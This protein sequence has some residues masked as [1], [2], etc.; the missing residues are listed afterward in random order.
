VEDCTRRAGHLSKQMSKLRH[1]VLVGL[2]FFAVAA[3]A[4]SAPEASLKVAV[5]RCNGQTIDDVSRRLRDYDRHA[6]SSS[7][8]Q[9]LARYGAIV[10]ALSTLGEEGDILKSVCSSESQT[11]EFYTQIAAL[12]AWALV[13]E[14]DVAGKLNASCA[15]AASGLP[16][17]MLADAWLALANRVNDGNGVVPSAFNDVIPKVQA[18]AQALD[19]TLPPWSETSQYW[20]DQVHTK[21]KMAI[22]TCPSPSPSPSP[23]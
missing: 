21:E 1:A 11:E 8:G 19:L 7:Q 16:T 2:M 20:R 22:A 3:P 4:G 18:R 12:T 13:L 5:S 10:D 23:S 6:P 15:A 14:A 17:M 9:L